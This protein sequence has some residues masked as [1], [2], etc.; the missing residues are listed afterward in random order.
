MLAVCSLCVH[1]CTLCVYFRGMSQ[2]G[3]K[4]AMEGRAGPCALGPL[5]EGGLCGLGQC[6]IHPP[7]VFPSLPSV[8]RS[9]SPG[10]PVT[11]QNGEGLDV[12]QQ[13]GIIRGRF[14]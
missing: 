1:M 11:V 4:G 6:P 13:E 14:G 8:N 9:V 12:A 7:R 5:C 10:K 2:D 3:L